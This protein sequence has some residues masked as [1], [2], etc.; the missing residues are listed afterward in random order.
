MSGLYN[1][2][3]FFFFSCTN[4]RKL[5]RL[6]LAASVGLAAAA[7]PHQWNTYLPSGGGCSGCWG[8]QRRQSAEGAANKARHYTK[9]QN[10]SE[11][12]GWFCIWDNSTA[13]QSESA[14]A[15]R[16][17]K[18]EDK[19]PSQHN[20][21]TRLTTAQDS[22]T[23]LKPWPRGQLCQPSPK[24]GPSPW[25]HST[26]AED[27]GRGELSSAQA[28]MQPTSGVSADEWLLCPISL[29]NP[30]WSGP[31]TLFYKLFPSGDLISTLADYLKYQTGPFQA[32]SWS[33]LYH[34]WWTCD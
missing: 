32:L 5:S 17:K 18:V 7:P 19:N 33:I 12:E 23:Q 10:K 34:P 31:H 30:P 28:A 2:W 3:E 1:E 29:P 9:K 20:K 27:R 4:S 25:Q 11:S 24:P 16:E 14:E 22:T 6:P 26:A 21:N 8:S 15:P 13:Q